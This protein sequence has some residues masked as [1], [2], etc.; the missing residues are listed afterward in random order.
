MCENVLNDAENVL[1]DN[2]YKGCKQLAS[3][4]LLEI[5]DKKHYFV[6]QSRTKI[7]NL[8]KGSCKIL[9][10]SPSIMKKKITNF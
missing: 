5:S 2:F 9:R 10:I 3:F 7:K 1:N 4:T 6:K 8:S